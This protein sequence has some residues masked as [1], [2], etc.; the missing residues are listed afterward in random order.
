MLILRHDS[1]DPP[2]MG[3]GPA[4]GIGRRCNGL[5]S[6]QGQLASLPWG[7]NGYPKRRKKKLE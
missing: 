4:L 5:G 3:S 2:S 7:S 1:H 6:M